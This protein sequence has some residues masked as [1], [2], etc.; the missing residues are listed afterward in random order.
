[1]AAVVEPHE[2][3][4]GLSALA[5]YLGMP[6]LTNVSK[7]WQ[8]AIKAAALWTVLSPPQRELPCQAHLTGAPRGP[9]GPS[10]LSPSLGWGEYMGCT[11]L[12]SSTI[13][14]MPGAAKSL[15]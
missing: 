6:S 3:A 15:T 1:M 13:P 7:R 12:Q 4:V 5:P 10:D 11:L 8:V 2:G 9:L 14:V